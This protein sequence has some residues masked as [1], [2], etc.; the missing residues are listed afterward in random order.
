MKV[1]ILDKDCIPT[2]NHS[3]DAG[4]DLRATESKLL[5]YRE[6]HL[7]GTGI[8]V[9]IPKGYCGLVVPRSGMGNKGAVLKNTVGV[10]DS[11]YRGE[12]FVKIKNTEENPLMIERGHRFVQLVIVPIYRYEMDFVES[13]D[14]TE[15]GE[16]GFGSSGVV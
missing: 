3:T 9:A 5:R 6:E 11:D 10:I 4:W 1:E 16:N 15:R 8:K 12:I 13:L 2:K 7:F 14:R